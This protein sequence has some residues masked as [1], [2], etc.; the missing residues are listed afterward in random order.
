[1]TI[2]QLYDDFE[3]IDDWEER[4]RYVIELGRNL[5]DIS[6]DLKTDANKVRGCASQVWLV[7]GSKADKLNFQGDSDAHIVK[8]LLAILIM[9]YSKKTAQQVLEIDAKAVFHKLGLEEHLSAQRANGLAAMIE[10][11]KTYAQHELSHS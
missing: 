7:A 2:E 1:M 10:R 9:L 6:E 4:Y 11:V 8:G 5:P 3:F